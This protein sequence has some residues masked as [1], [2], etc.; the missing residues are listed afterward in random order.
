MQTLESRKISGTGTAGRREE[1]VISEKSEEE[2]WGSFFL[3]E[4]TPYHPTNLTNQTIFLLT[5][6]KAFFLSSALNDASLP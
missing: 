6:K 2:Y 1:T 4:V 5:N 3:S